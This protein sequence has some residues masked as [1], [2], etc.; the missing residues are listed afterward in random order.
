[1]RALSDNAEYRAV[2]AVFV[3]AA[4]LA[5]HDSECEVVEV[6]EVVFTES[7]KIVEQQVLK[8]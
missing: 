8:Y 7:E 4:L 5:S 3:L 2:A 1:V 6:V